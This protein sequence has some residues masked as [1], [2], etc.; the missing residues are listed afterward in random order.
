MF[1]QRLINPDWSSSNVW[2]FHITLH[3]PNDSCGVNIF[4]GNSDAHCY[5]LM[6]LFNDAF[7][8]QLHSAVIESSA[9]SL[10]GTIFLHF[11]SFTIHKYKL[12]PLKGETA[13]K[14]R[15]VSYLLWI[16]KNR[17]R[18]GLHLWCSKVTRCE[19]KSEKEG[20]FIF[21]LF[22]TKNIIWKSMLNN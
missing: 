10:A 1:Y 2:S 8:L 16:L 18:K 22:F 11:L 13:N 15:N 4:N 12:I 14:Y 3:T 21:C 5:F 20:F 19:G 17:K 7:H 9:A 6:D